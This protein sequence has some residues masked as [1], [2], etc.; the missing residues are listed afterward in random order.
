[1]TKWKYTKNRPR[2]RFDARIL[3]GI[4][5]TLRRRRRRRRRHAVQYAL[6]VRDDATKSPPS[7]QRISIRILIKGQREDRIGNNQPHARM[8]NANANWFCRL[9]NRWFVVLVGPFLQY[10]L[11]SRSKI[12]M[13]GRHHLDDCNHHHDASRHSRLGRDSK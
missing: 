9:R 13:D 5:T 4:T 1:L 7:K 11:A 12:I 8:H 3:L 10:H 6:L 2:N